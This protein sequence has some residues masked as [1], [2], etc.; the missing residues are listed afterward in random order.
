MYGVFSRFYS[1]F[2]SVGVIDNLNQISKK[3]KSVSQTFIDRYIEIA[4]TN[5]HLNDDQLFDR[6]T[7]QLIK[8]GIRLKGTDRKAVKI[9]GKS[10]EFTHKREKRPSIASIALS[11]DN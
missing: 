8:E 3:H 10:Q 7:D 11:E 2:G 6:T 1:T 5:G 4:A 9:G